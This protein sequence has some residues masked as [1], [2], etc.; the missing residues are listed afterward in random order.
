MGYKMKNWIL[1][2]AGRRHISANSQD[3]PLLNVALLFLRIF[4]N[5]TV[6]KAGTRAI[7]NYVRFMR[8]FDV[9]GA[10][11]VVALVQFMEWIGDQ[12]NDA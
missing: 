9:E 5:C 1:D 12:I 4:W 10:A 2:S 6:S 8:G 11:A 3:A 7:I